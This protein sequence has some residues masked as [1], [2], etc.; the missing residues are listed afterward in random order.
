M[1]DTQKD[2]RGLFRRIGEF[3]IRKSH[4][5]ESFRMLKQRHEREVA[6]Y[7]AECPHRSQLLWHPFWVCTN[8]EKWVRMATDEEIQAESK[9]RQDELVTIIKENDIAFA[10]TE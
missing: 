2:S 4:Q 1:E 8:C 5:A 10:E 3:F 6:T 9:L 7:Q